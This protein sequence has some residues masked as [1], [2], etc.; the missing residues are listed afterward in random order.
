[1]LILD[2]TQFLDYGPLCSVLPGLS[3]SAVFGNECFRSSLW[4]I[5]DHVELNSG[6]SYHFSP[7]S[8][9]ACTLRLDMLI[10]ILEQKVGYS[11]AYH[12]NCKPFLR[13]G[14]PFRMQFFP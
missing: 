1:M 2:G 3:A 12:E 13:F 7:L 4:K 8:N 5:C 9:L 14:K 11:D 10:V 6:I